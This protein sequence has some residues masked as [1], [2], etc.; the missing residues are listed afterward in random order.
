MLS[1]QD[2]LSQVSGASF[3]S[4]DTITVPV[5]TG[6]KKNPFQ[7]MIHKVMV[8]ANVMVFSMKHGGSAYENM[9]KRRLVKEWKDAESFVLGQR[10]WGTRVEGTPFVEH[11]G[12][13]YLEVI[14]LK[15]GTSHYLY[16]GHPIDSSDIV[17]LKDGE[18]SDQGG[19]DNK[20]VI[21]TF[22]VDNIS[23][24]TVDGQRHILN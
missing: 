1:I 6:G 14:F 5:L 15:A 20:V 11:N 21:R 13:L 22:R 8:G 4:I 10:A 23:S 19:L 24:I 16:D 9:V 3:I 2:I 7:G 18:K 17:G 12:Q